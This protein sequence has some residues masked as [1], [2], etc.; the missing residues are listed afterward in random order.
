MSQVGFYND[1]QYRDYPF[2]HAPRD[3]L[4]YELAQDAIVD[5]GFTLG[6]SVLYDPRQDSISLTSVAVEGMNLKYTFALFRG[7]IQR[8]ATDKPID[9][10]AKNGIEI[11]F[12]FPKD[13]LPFSTVY[14]DFSFEIGDNV[15]DDLTFV[16][17]PFQPAIC[18]FDDT[19]A[20]L[21]TFTNTAATGFLTIGNSATVID[22]ITRRGGFVSFDGVYAV[23]PANIHSAQKHYLNSVRVGNMPRVVVPECSDLPLEL[24]PEPE[25][26]GEEELPPEPIF[27]RNSLLQS[28]IKF[29]A[30][31]N[32]RLAQNNTTNTITFTP[33]LG[34]GIDSSDTDL[35][36]YLGEL[37]FTELE[38]FVFTE[39]TAN[40]N[41][42]YAWK[43]A[44]DEV[45]GED[46]D[47]IKEVYETLIKAQGLTI[48]VD[49][50]DEEVKSKYLSGGKTC[51]EA[52]YS[53]NGLSGKNITIIAGPNVDI[54]TGENDNEIVVSRLGSASGG[55]S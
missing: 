52:I 1:N 34:A 25:E 33:F 5:A 13:T 27:P 54:T 23:E 18:R 8:R 19:F 43:K 20:A 49:E 29:V 9:H 50:N 24:P 44:Y 37:P 26:E 38:A 11:V 22:D 21:K 42:P 12:S 48:Y 15:L 36:D 6:P 10:T 47:K 39:N 32:L 45:V 30:G 35:C 28:D 7:D 31:A 16:Y 46:A 40:K 3:A 41:L 17:S 55:C 51:A 53:I 2:I 4:F 14:A